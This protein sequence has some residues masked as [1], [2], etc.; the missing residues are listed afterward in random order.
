MSL[1]NTTLFI[2]AMILVGLIVVL[3]GSLNAIL[4]PYFQR[5]EHND[6]L[7]NT[8]RGLAAFDSRL[9]ELQRISLLW[10]ASDNGF[11]NPVSGIPDG[12]TTLPTDKTLI[13]LDIDL[14]ATFDAKS[15]LRNG[16]YLPL[17]AQSFEDIPADLAS[18]LKKAVSEIN[19]HS[20]RR[21]FLQ[22]GT[23]PLMVVI[24]PSAQSILIIGRYLDS[25]VQQALDEE[26]KLGISITPFVDAPPGSEVFSIQNELSV[27][28]QPTVQIV[29]NDLVSGYGLLKDPLGNPGYIIRIDQPRTYYQNSQMILNYLIIT[30]ASSTVIFSTMTFLL[31]E[32]LV[33]KRLSKLNK[34]VQSIAIDGRSAA[35]VTVTRKDELANLS[36]N[37]NQMLERLVKTQAELETSYSLVRQGRKRLEDLSRRLVDTQEEERHSIAMELH[38]EI[39]QSLTALKLQLAACAARPSNVNADDLKNMQSLLNTLIDRVRNLSLQLR[40]A[41]LDDLGLLPTLL[42][43]FEEFEKQTNIKVNFKHKNVGKTRFTPA[44]E[45]GAYRIVQESLTN[46]AR[47]AGTDRASVT[48]ERMSDRLHLEINDQGKGFSVEKA[49]QNP[50]SSGLSGMRERVTALGGKLEITSRPGKGTS[51]LIDLPFDGRLERRR[52]ARHHPAG[53]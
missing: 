7:L 29:S 15:T 35:R 24:S 21:G 51:L 41:M 43:H 17:D 1:R 16:K 11:V 19:D 5:Q 42:W 10:N 40:P 6:V 18:Q 36:H 53:G 45:V 20:L 26:L 30:V 4:P 44:L 8:R 52:N 32:N 49:L 27:S 23:T 2:I 9:D 12:A 28:G 25:S 48:M 13:A 39:G 14:I 47:H 37:I 38:D 33:L 22:T 31:I 50:N 34:E 46:I 3:L